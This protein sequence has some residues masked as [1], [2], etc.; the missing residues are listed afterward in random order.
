MG[1]MKYDEDLMQFLFDNYIY[2]YG[3]DHMPGSP[4]IENVGDGDFQIGEGRPE[5]VGIFWDW[6]D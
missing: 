3:F 5:Q 6:N 2:N 1:D 4:Y